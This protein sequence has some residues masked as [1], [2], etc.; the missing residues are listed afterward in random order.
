MKYLICLIYAALT[1]FSLS[2]LILFSTN[3]ILFAG[4]VWRSHG[5]VHVFNY[6]KGSSGKFSGQKCP[7]IIF[8]IKTRA[9]SSCSSVVVL[10]P[11]H[12]HFYV[13]F[14]IC[15]SSAYADPKSR[16]Y[17]KAFC[18][19]AGVRLDCYLGYWRRKGF[20]CSSYPP[21]RVVL[22]R[23][24]LPTWDTCVVLL[25]SRAFGL[26]DTKYVFQLH[27]RTVVLGFLLIMS[28]E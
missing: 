2:Y 18:G 26:R 23:P 16:L 8:L 13:G 20:I 11:P 19:Q 3:I 10:L 9:W 22:K 5:T 24:L 1:F 17:L 7:P 21:A 12:R 4:E 25:S 6:S 14:L 15:M 27:L 28:K